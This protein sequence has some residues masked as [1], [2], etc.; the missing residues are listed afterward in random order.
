[1]Y[2]YVL[3]G[4]LSRMQ[5]DASDAS[6]R[7]LDQIG[8]AAYGVSPAKYPVCRLCDLPM[9]FVAQFK[10]DAKRLDLGR[11]NRVLYVFDCLNDDESRNPDS[12][13]NACFVLEPEEM[14]NAFTAAPENSDFI[15]FYSYTTKWKRWSEGVP[16]KF[17][18]Q[19]LTFTAHH[20]LQQAG[21]LDNLVANSKL[22]GVPV[23]LQ[24][25]EERFAQEGWK[26]AGQINSKDR[27][28]TF[29]DAD[30]IRFIWGGG[31]AYIFI[32]RPQSSSVPDC[33]FFFQCT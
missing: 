22:G 26:F 19:F 15:E 9:T 13:T 7:L 23:W 5:R 6:P 16:G 25:P 3:N 21:L 14:T 29:N 31:I 24:N 18:G 32:N 20:Q 33:K 10:H 30:K 12:G 4:Y 28:F 27:P 8:G 1:M 17:A 11:E 2:C